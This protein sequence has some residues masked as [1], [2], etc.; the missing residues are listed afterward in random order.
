MPSGK[1]VATTD[2]SHLHSAACGSLQGDTTVSLHA[3]PERQPVA[4][5]FGVG[6]SERSDMDVAPPPRQYSVIASAQKEQVTKWDHHKKSPGLAEDTH[7][8]ANQTP[9]PVP[10]VT[11]QGGEPYQTM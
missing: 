8:P 3:H 10:T 9:S 2:V 5:A 7:L 4:V 1:T 6:A 11:V